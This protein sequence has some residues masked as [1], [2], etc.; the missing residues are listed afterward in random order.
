MTLGSLDYLYTPS[1]DVAAD[2]R[3][4]VDVLGGEE[5][6]AIEDGGIRV[7]MVQL[8]AAPAIL[9][10]DHLEGD[11]PIHLF[12]VDDLP[13]AAAELEGR[14][15]STERSVELPPGPA[16]TFRTPGG[17]RMAIYQPLRPF[18]VESFRGRHDFR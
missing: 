12:A 5:A 2:L 13:S 10:T 7:A 8:G 1:A 9:L 6:F 4:L 3:Y 14:G 16:M 18:V 15:W 17:L 11:R